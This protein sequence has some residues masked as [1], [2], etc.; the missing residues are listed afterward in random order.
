[1]RLGAM[2]E[3]LALQRND[4]VTSTGTGRR[5]RDWETYATVAGEY[6]EPAGGTEQQQRAAVVAELLPSFRIRYR[7]DV[8][9]KHQLLWRGQ[10][11]QITAVIAEMK[12]GNRWLLLR[13][14]L[15][16]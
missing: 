6:L 5:T 14:G 9:P 15:T 2:R 13:T 3:S 4:E 16:Q 12:T 8:K 11:L 7:I 1:M 10:T